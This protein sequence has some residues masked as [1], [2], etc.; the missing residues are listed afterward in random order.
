MGF[1]TKQREQIIELVPWS[2]HPSGDCSCRERTIH[3]G[4]FQG[5]SETCGRCGQLIGKKEWNPAPRRLFGIRY[6]RNR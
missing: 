4:R 2:F 5:G 6:G 1:T 3:T